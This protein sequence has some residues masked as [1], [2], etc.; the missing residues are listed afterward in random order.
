MIAL[1]SRFLTALG[2]LTFTEPAGGGEGGGP[3][4]PEKNLDVHRGL[5][6][7]RYEIDNRSRIPSYMFMNES[8]SSLPDS[9]FVAA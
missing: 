4:P 1:G 6:L 2:F 9:C 5:S 7:R 3:P 8:S